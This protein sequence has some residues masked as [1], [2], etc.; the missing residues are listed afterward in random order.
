MWDLSEHLGSGVEAK[1]TGRDQNFFL[2]E[3]I[4]EPFGEVQKEYFQSIDVDPEKIFTIRQVHGATV[5]AVGTR[6]DSSAPRIPEADGMIT[7]K[8]DIV[9]SI[10]TADCVPIF[11]Y[12]PVEKGIGLVHAGWRSARHG[13]AGKALR[14]M[15]QHF[16]TM[17]INVKAVLGPGIRSCCYQVGQEM[18][19]IFPE[20]M[21]P[22]GG[23]W[24]L[25]LAAV[26]AA[27]LMQ[28]GMLRENIYDAQ[29][30]TCCDER[31][32]S[33]RRDGEKAGRHLS[34]LRIKDEG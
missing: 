19:G 20:Q 1:V 16:G 11:L 27:H 8:K 12:D 4:Q 5:L 21:I 9:L 31:F 7:N 22:K 2:S 28:V 32:F 18:C 34:L 10:R 23:D 15:Q 3:D 6:N 17:P 26:N 14:E 30:C 29:M 13:I 24:F 33:Y 25:D